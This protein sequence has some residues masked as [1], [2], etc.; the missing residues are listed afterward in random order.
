MIPISVSDIIKL[1]EQIPIWKAIRELPKRITELEA[2]VASLEAER[3]TLPQAPKIPEARLC[4]LCHAEMKVTRE[5]PHP[6]FDFAGLKVH[7]MEC[8]SCGNTATRDFQ[9]GKGYR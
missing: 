6:E 8:T 2:R 3:R 7:H 4:P 1:L 9:P 5:A